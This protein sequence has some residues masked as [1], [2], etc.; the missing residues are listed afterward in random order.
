MINFFYDSY[1]MFIQ[2]LIPGIF[3]G[4][5]YDIFYLLRIE[6]NE[7]EVSLWRLTIKRYFPN[8]IK[9][10]S[11]NHIKNKSLYNFFVFAEDICFFF[12]VAII[13]I[14]AIYYLNDGEIRI[15]CLLFSLIGFFSYQK[16]IGLFLRFLLIKLSKLLKNLLFMCICIIMEPIAF[17]IKKCKQMIASLDFKKRFQRRKYPKSSFKKDV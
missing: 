13:E 6:K 10:N 14:L 11:K 1:L 5:I 17:I 4:I 2:F 8:K 7:K 12:I 9:E 15:Y 16:T 3:L